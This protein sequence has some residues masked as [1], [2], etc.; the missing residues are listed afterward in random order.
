MFKHQLSKIRGEFVVTTNHDAHLF[1]EGLHCEISVSTEAEF[2]LDVDLD[3]DFN[4]CEKLVI[5]FRPS[6]AGW[7]KAYRRLRQEFKG[8]ITCF[9]N[10]VQPTLRTRLR[11]KKMLERF[12]ALTH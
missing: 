4:V 9:D 7:K 8:R 1:N 2:D 10:Q 3:A 12:H 11:H 6:R 5:T